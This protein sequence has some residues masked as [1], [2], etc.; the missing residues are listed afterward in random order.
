MLLTAAGSVLL[1]IDMQQR[2]LP[3]IHDGDAVVANAV[4]LAEA[5]RGH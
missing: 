5:F 1:L 4:R 3:A 2:L